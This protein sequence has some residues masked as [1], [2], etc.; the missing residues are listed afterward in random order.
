MTAKAACTSLHRFFPTLTGLEASTPM[1]LGMGVHC[2]LIFFDKLH[3]FYEH[4][5]GAK[6][7]P[8]R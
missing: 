4:K 7:K 3:P 2:Q 5:L 1:L 6:E 8:E